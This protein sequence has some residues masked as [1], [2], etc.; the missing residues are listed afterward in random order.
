M[1]TDS[2]VQHPFVRKVITMN[3]STDNDFYNWLS[4]Q[5]TQVQTN[6]K[7]ILRHESK[8]KNMLRTDKTVPDEF[9]PIM[10]TSAGDN[11]DNTC[12]RICVSPTL[13]NCLAG[14]GRVASDLVDHPVLEHDENNSRGGYYISSFD[15][16]YA[17]AVN[18]CLVPEANSTKEH[19]LVAY[20]SDLKVVKPKPIG[21]C[22]V[23]NITYMN[24]GGNAPDVIYELLVNVYNNNSLWLDESNKVDQGYWKL[25]VTSPACPGKR[26]NFANLTSFKKIDSSE[27]TECKARSAI[28][29]DLSAKTFPLANW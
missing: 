9:Y 11:E 15:Y 20:R 5:T 18:Q 23:K 4:L 22:F 8:Y 14:Y 10:P 1:L 17:L 12:P 16:E 3:D 28:L 27:Y 2:I 24:K 13:L 25:L 7:V 26:L 21:V 6:S 19:W 29:L